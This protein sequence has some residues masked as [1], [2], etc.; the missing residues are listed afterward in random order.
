MTSTFRRHFDE[1]IA[2]AESLLELANGNASV[3]K[4]GT[5]ADDLRL[6]AIAMGVGAMDAYFCDAYADCLALR[7]QSA[8][9]GNL[10]LPKSYEKRNL[11]TTLLIR[12]KQNLR[13]NWSLRMAARSVM[14]RENVLS[15]DTV[16]HLFNP[17]LPKGQKLWASAMEPII[18]QNWKRLTGTYLR[19]YRI[20]SSK[21]QKGARGTAAKQM[22][23]R[24]KETIQY[25][26]DWIHNCGRPRS[27]VQTLSVGQALERMR[28][29]KVVVTTF[30]KHLMDH[31]LV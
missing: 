21:S 7:L 15:L 18:A 22:K 12:P 14:E 17:V 10:D 27:T 20:L 25:R 16:E 6:S 3:M 4:A 24:I 29:L 19:D 30:D 23:K 28:D 11:P 13:E 8:K 1:D 2:R 26:H 5:R 9:A 31:R